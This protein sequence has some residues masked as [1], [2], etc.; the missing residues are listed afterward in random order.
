MK[1]TFKFNFY[2]SD[3][4]FGVHIRHL[5]KELYYSAWRYVKKGDT[6]VGVKKIDGMPE[7]T[8]EY[9][10][11]LNVWANSTLSHMNPNPT[12][13][14]FIFSEDEL[15]SQAKY[16]LNIWIKLSNEQKTR[17][18]RGDSGTVL[19]LDLLT[20]YISHFELL[21]LNGQPLFLRM[22]GDFAR[23]VI[24]KI[25]FSSKMLK[26]FEHNWK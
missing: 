23:D 2:P 4:Y 16:F 22:P 13:P 20:K 5:L 7:C 25:N 26:E 18:C 1:D 14:H 12:L 11:S 6:W 15:S 8:P 19:F 10:I 3:Y 24:K 9:F 17:L 21:W